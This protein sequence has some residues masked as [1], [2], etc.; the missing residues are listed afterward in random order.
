MA[1][2][3]AGQKIKATDELRLLQKLNSKFLNKISIMPGGGFNDKNVYKFLNAG[4]RQIHL[5]AKTHNEVTTEDPV[6]NLEIIKYVVTTTSLF[7]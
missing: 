2:L 5:S 6:S 1:F 3:T 7:E 4:F